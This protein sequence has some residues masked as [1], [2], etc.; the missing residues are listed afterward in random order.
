MCEDFG[1]GQHKGSNKLSFEKI[2]ERCTMLDDTGQLTSKTLSVNCDE[3]NIK[4][5]LR[6]LIGNPACNMIVACNLDVIFFFLFSRCFSF[7]LFSSNFSSKFSFVSFFLFLFSFF[8]FL[9]CS[10]SFSCGKNMLDVCCVPT[11][12]AMVKTRNECQ[13]SAYKLLLGNLATAVCCAEPL[14]HSTRCLVCCMRNGAR[15][16]PQNLTVDTAS[17]DSRL[18]QSSKRVFH[19][20]H[21]LS[22]SHL[23]LSLHALVNVAEDGKPQSRIKMCNFHRS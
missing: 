4:R 18:H 17:L 19:N 10:F 1:F 7:F 5:L 11:S 16:V 23:V 2:A 14:C 20:I 13:L 22:L 9:V 6:Y 3:V 21:V 12:S 15:S 8:V